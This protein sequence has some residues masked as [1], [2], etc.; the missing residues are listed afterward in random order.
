M[1]T[2]EGL[3]DNPYPSGVRK[4]VGTVNNYRIRI[5]QYRVIYKVESSCLIIE[6]IKVGHRQGIY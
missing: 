3:S 6:I 5:D 4:L 2:I 1:T